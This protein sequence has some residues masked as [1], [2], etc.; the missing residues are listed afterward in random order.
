[1]ESP[2]S[3][4]TNQTLF[5]CDLLSILFA[6]LAAAGDVLTRESLVAG[7]ETITDFPLALWGNLTFSSNDHAG[8]E[9]VRTTKWSTACRCWSAL[10]DFA[11]PLP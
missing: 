4:E 10:D 3:G 6:G 5:T 11:D 8:V 2:E 9:Q 1:L 7:L